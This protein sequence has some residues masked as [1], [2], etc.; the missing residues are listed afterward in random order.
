[1]T[2]NLNERFIEVF[3]EHR[4]EGSGDKIRTFFSPG[5]VNLIGEYTDF[6]GGHVLPCALTIGTY[7][8]VSANQVG[9]IRLYSENFKELGMQS[10]DTHGFVFDEKNGWTNYALGV[11]EQFEKL[12]YQMPHGMDLLFSGNIPNGAGLSSSASLE[13]AVAVVINDLFGFGLEMLELVKL[14]QKAENEFVGVQCGIMD[15]FAIGMGKKG[16]AVLLDTNTMTYEYTKLEMENTVLVIANTNKKRE[17]ADS[18]YNER[19]EECEMALRELQAVVEI[20]S[21]GEL[22]ETTFE[23]Y[24]GAIASDVRR[25]RAKHAVYENQRTLK[26]LE[27]MQDND[28]DAFGKLMNAS[29][30]SLRDDFEVSCKEL[31]VLVE[32]ALEHSGVLGARMTGAGFGGCTVNLVAESEVDAFVKEV[33]ARYKELTGYEADFYKVRPGDGTGEII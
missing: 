18:K 13:V 16:R 3:G 30:V 21:L 32:L 23:K 33:G 17:L 9:R 19:R 12:G 5:R 15:Q 24:S 8:L 10:F 11:F 29:H 22:N 2:A 14:S 26:A 4:G 7:A 20:N 27:V 28:L 6:N 1:M 31:D 25:K